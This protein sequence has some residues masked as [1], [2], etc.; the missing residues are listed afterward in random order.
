MAQINDVAA[1]RGREQAEALTQYLSDVITLEVRD[2]VTHDFEF[3][4]D[5][6][7]SWIAS[8]VEAFHSVYIPWIAK[9]IQPK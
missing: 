6:G 2:G 7:N 1:D 8:F 9:Q 4:A 5:I 3:Y